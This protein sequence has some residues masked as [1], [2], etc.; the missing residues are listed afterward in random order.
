MKKIFTIALLVL[1][2][3]TLIACSKSDEPSISLYLAVKR[4]DIDQIERH[5]NWG[6]DINKINIDGQTPLHVTAT[7]GRI[8]AAKLLLKNGAE[9]NKLNNAGEGAEAIV[10]RQRPTDP[11]T[12]P[13][14]RPQRSVLEHEN[15]NEEWEE[16]GAAW[17]EDGGA[18]NEPWEEDATLIQ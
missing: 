2:N 11:R 18:W 10:R 6:A 12:R 16:D 4:G 3:F 15:P 8:V 5:I 7:A 9:I 1:M 17:E 13:I 14:S